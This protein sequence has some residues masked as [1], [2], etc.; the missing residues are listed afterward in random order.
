[1]EQKQLDEIDESYFGEEFIEEETPEEHMVL[2]AKHER[3]AL[4]AKR[5]AEKAA[6]EVKESVKKAV[7][8]T[9]KIEPIK[10][11]T[12]HDEPV[13]I[14]PAKEELKQVTAVKDPIETAKPVNP[15]ASEEP[16][17]GFHEQSRDAKGFVNLS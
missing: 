8:D 7:K 17:T 12:Y 1:M 13:T 6:K 15:W 4:A 5:L 9:K 10:V 2:K 11:E 16:E 3:K 14:K